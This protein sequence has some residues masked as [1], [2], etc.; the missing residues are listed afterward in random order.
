MANRDT[1]LFKTYPKHWGIPALLAGSGVLFIMGLVLPAITLKEL[2]FWTNTFSVLTGIQSLFDEGH[3]L[4]GL[5]IMLFSIFF[6]FFKMIILSMV[7]FSEL[8]SGKREFYVH[9]LGILGKWSMLD[10]F[11]VAVTI[12]VTKIS[13]LAKANAEVG[14]YFFGAS[15]VLAMI[16]TERI[17]RIIQTN[18]N[19]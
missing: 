10:V 11:V 9:W 4:L 2:I 6:P 1:S 5:I 17:E 3:Y 19:S 13:G 14:I 8:P 18:K 16:V 7:W 12:V 15:V